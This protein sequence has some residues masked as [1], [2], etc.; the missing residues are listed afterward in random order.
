MAEEIQ[1]H[2]KSKA[3]QNVSLVLR[4]I[5]GL[6]GFYQTFYGETSI[7]I[8]ILVCFALITFPA[9]FSRNFIKKFPIEIEII[10]C[11]MV[12]IQMVMGEARDLYVEIPKYD[13]FVHWLFPMFLGIMGFII[14]YMLYATDRM[15]ISTPAMLITI[16]LISLGVGALWEIFEF[17]SDT[18]LLP[19]IPGWHQFQGSGAQSANVD[20]MTDLMY[21]LV[22][23]I[24]GALLGLWII[25]FPNY[26]V[27]RLPELVKEVNDIF[28]PNTVKKVS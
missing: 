3:M 9:F 1:T 15:T 10:L 25:K 13:K 6:S 4:I 11:V 19:I 26:R 5:I 28:Y 8:L 17:L 21:D 24:S 23:A 12:V 27:N 7:G 20:T 2:E 18:L 16:I 22:G 14:F